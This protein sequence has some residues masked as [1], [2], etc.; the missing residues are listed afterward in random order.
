MRLAE[1]FVPP[2]DPGQFEDHPLGV[3]HLGERGIGL[4]TEARRVDSPFQSPSQLGSR[5]TALRLS[6]PTSVL[7]P[8]SRS[9]HLGDAATFLPLGAKPDVEHRLKLKSKPGHERRTSGQDALAVVAA[10]RSRSLSAASSYNARQES[11]KDARSSRPS[12]SNATSR[13]RS[14][15]ATS[16]I[17]FEPA[18]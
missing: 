1:R 17:G 11:G 13:G 4:A 16:V 18:A 2:V 5:F 7:Q 15:I 10:C 9:L 12:R 6:S 8:P 14:A 3:P